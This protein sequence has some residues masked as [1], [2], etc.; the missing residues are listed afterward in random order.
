MP[1]IPIRARRGAL[2]AILVASALLIVSPSFAQVLAIRAGTVVDP[3][4][5]S[6]AKDQSANPREAAD[7]KPQ[8][9][10]LRGPSGRTEQRC[11]VARPPEDIGGAALLNGE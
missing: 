5:G 3:A 2:A 6:S 11:N 9:E 10:D 7:R 8:T 1:S 4:R